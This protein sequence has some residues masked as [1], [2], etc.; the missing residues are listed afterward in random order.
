MLRG[1]SAQEAAAERATARM[2]QDAKRA[3]HCGAPVNGVKGLAV[4]SRLDAYD[5]VWG[6]CPDYMRSS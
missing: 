5:V 4:L 2:K 6:T 1:N 3:R